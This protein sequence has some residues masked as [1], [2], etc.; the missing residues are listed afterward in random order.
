MALA[1]RLSQP[2]QSPGKPGKAGL[3][4]GSGYALDLGSLIENHVRD[5]K[6]ELDSHVEKALKKA[7]KSGKLREFERI[8]QALIEAGKKIEK[9]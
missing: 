2:D 1:A 5:A 4:T 8:H 9:F 7:R 3:G 6:D